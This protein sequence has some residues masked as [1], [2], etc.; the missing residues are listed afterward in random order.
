MLPVL[1]ALALASLRQGDDP[2]KILGVSQSAT[3]REIKDAFRALTMKLHPDKNPGRDTTAE[4]V[5][6][7]DAYELLNDPDRRTLFD[8]FAIV[9]DQPPPPRE[10]TGFEGMAER[11]FTRSSRVLVTPETL[12]LDPSNIDEFLAAPEDAAILVYS[13]VMCERCEDYLNSFETIANSSNEWARFAR[14]DVAA[15]EELARR[16]KVRSMPTIVYY[17]NASG[18]VTTDS[19][20]SLIRDGKEGI[21]FLTSHWRL[22][23]EY[24]KSDGALVK[25]LKRNPGL[26]KVIQIVKKSDGTLQYQK[27]AAEHYEFAEFAVI[28]KDKFPPLQYPITLYPTWVVYRHLS[29]PYRLMTTLKEVRVSLQNWSLPT[30]LELHR[31]NYPDLCGEVCCVRIGRAPDATIEKLTSVN[32]STFWIAPGKASRKLG[33]S[34]G[35]WVVLRPGDGKFARLS[36]SK[37]DEGRSLFREFTD[38]HSRDLRKLPRGFALDWQL[39]PWLGHAWAVVCRLYRWI[40]IVVLD[41]ALIAGL[42]GWQARSYISGR[43]KKAA[44]A[45]ASPTTSVS[46]PASPGPPAGE[47]SDG[48][49]EKT[50]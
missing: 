15:N 50:E 33:A 23:I 14:I 31:F 7:N 20:R 12:L 1:V 38:V 2:Y 21:D 34:D 26:P 36:V 22:H 44:G 8:R 9:G 17:K 3:V 46:P 43:R 49:K 10:G 40:D 5:Q 13:S 19:L 41:G 37:R 29:I 6:V 47:G 18:K 48:E 25:F 39:M 35:S 16:L 24:L 11:H 45:S 28:D 32:V 27:L 42:V 30:M 4:W